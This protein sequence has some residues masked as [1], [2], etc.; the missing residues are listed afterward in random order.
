MSLKA[1]NIG[2]VLSPHT[3]YATEALADISLTLSPGTILGMV[4]ETGSGKSSLLQVM[5]GLQPPTSG[6]V[7]V[8]ELPVYG[9]PQDTPQV[10]RLIGISFQYPEYQFFEET[11]A[12][13]LAFGLQ[14]QGLSPEVVAERSAAAL[15]LVQLP[16]SLLPRSPFELSGGQ[17]RRLALAITFSLE[18][19]YLLLDEPLA[20]LDPAGREAVMAAISAYCREREAAV[21]FV[22]HNME[23]VTRVA[24]RLLVM[25]QGHLML[26]ATP[27]EV[28]SHAEAIQDAGLELPPGYRLLA[29]LQQRGLEIPP[30]YP[31]DREQFYRLLRNLLT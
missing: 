15:H 11:V 1:K 31:T 29:E 17:M 28:F 27:W 13:E 20:G 25:R 30:S 9:S 5:A 18:P 10:R 14:R 22:S 19:K 24:H 2:L 7:T 6:A 21:L 3:I 4:G 12:R 23:E 8:D 26:D 16:L